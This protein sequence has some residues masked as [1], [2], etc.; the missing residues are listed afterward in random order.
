MSKWYAFPGR[1]YYRC[2]NGGWTMNQVCNNAYNDPR[3]Y[4]NGHPAV[5]ER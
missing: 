3:Y 4:T 5:H 1:S 2:T